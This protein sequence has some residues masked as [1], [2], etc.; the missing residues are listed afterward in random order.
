[1]RLTTLATRGLAAR[2]LRSALAIVGIAL[3]VAVV[4]ATLVI[5]ASSEAAVR[6]A[7]ADLLGTA[8]VRL[9]AFAD[10]GFGPQDA[11]GA[12]CRP[13]RRCGCAGERAT[14]H[15]VEPLEPG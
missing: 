4:S 6:A 1:M 15:R 10:A 8:D 9:R 3:G 13:R 12:S 11:P 2:P 7:T 5:G 14:H